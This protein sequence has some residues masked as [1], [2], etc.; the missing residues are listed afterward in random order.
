M[1]PSTLLLS[2]RAKGAAPLCWCEPALTAPQS[3]GK[4]KGLPL[5]A[6]PMGLRAAGLLPLQEPSSAPAPS[7]SPWHGL[8]APREFQLAGQRGAGSCSNGV[9]WGSMEGEGRLTWKLFRVEGLP[10]LCQLT[11]PLF[12][13]ARVQIDY[14][15]RFLTSPSPL[16]LV[17][18]AN[19]QS[20]LQT[21]PHLHF[22]IFTT[23][24]H[25]ALLTVPH[26]SPFSFSSPSLPLFFLCA[27]NTLTLQ[28]F[29]INEQWKSWPKSQKTGEKS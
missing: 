5:R 9:V 12:L 25:P 4:S 27:H 7:S 18:P 20:T 8:S 26:I 1:S 19:P 28:R 29:S 15:A 13:P 24:S 14:R 21:S 22:N 10:R 3:W 17:S 16:E 11:V 6:D 23:S 2:A